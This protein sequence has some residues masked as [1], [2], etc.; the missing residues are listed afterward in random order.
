MLM[1]RTL[2]LWIHAGGAMR[3]IVTHRPLEL[4]SALHYACTPDCSELDHMAWSKELSSSTS[5]DCL[6]RPI[7]IAC[8]EG[9]VFWRSHSLVHAAFRTLRRI[10]GRPKHRRSFLPT[11][12]W[13]A[14]QTLASRQDLLIIRYAV[15]SAALEY[16]PLRKLPSTHR[17]AASQTTDETE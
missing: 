16:A 15:S 6:Y 17:R 4:S 2:G 14:G 10:R 1:S 7:L 13:I 11:P 9:V 3:V 8:I 12:Q 5:F